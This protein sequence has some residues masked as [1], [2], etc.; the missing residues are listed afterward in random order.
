LTYFGQKV[1][2][3]T[4]HN[5][6][7][8]I[9]PLFAE[10]LGMEVVVHEADTDQLGTFSGIIP[11]LGTMEETVV[12]K[13]KIG[14][15]AAGCEFGIASEGAFGPHPISGFLPVD[16]EMIAFIDRKNDFK[17]IETILSTNTNY[18]PN[19]KNDMRAHM[20]PM[21]MRVIHQVCQK[22]VQR[23]A[24]MCPACDL[25]G[26]GCV[27]LVR[28]LPCETCGLKT[29]LVKAEVH[30]CVKCDFRQEQAKLLQYTVAP[31]QY[32]NFCNP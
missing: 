16:T 18:N 20:N 31:M 5:K 30:G 9:A 21:R 6:E 28:G 15:E 13:A 14:L 10:V 11:R 2:L 17:I 19:L 32:C 24:R 8:V 25:P 12:A 7:Q 22:L 3:T 26:F 27:D 4:K 1:V 29:D 23:L